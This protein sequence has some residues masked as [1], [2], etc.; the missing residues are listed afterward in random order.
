VPKGDVNNNNIKTNIKTTTNVAVQNKNIDENDV[1]SKHEDLEIFKSLE[2]LNF[3]ASGSSKRQVIENLFETYGEKRLIEVYEAYK[4]ASSSPMQTIAN[5]VGFII[6]ALKANYEFIDKE[7]VVT[8][9]RK[10][11]DEK[12]SQ[13]LF[14][15]TQE[16]KEIQEKKQQQ[17]KLL[18][19]FLSKP[20]NQK[21]YDVIYTQEFELASKKFKESTAKTTAKM[22]ARQYILDTFFQT[23]NG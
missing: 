11:R 16:A 8:E 2:A 3:N 7:K 13:E 12:A 21:I 4:K 23:D 9:K 15:K 22:K 17:N 20:Q 19:A 6:Q 18:E 1:T 14:Q 10:E 5:P